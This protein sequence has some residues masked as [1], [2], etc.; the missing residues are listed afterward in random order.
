[1]DE[2]Y[3]EILEI[4]LMGIQ[5]KISEA[6]KELQKIHCLPTNEIP[7]KQQ[8]AEQQEEKQEHFNFPTEEEAA[9]D[10]QDSDIPF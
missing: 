2:R 3:L 6:Q 4:L 8:P 7:E 1:M 9:E 10:D 5:E